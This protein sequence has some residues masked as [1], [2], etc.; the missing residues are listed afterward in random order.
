MCTPGLHETQLLQEGQTKQTQQE[1][2]ALP[3]VCCKYSAAG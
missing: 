3:S 1:S 2:Q